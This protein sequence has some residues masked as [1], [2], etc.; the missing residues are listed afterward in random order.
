VLGS[1]ARR[2]LEKTLSRVDAVVAADVIG[3]SSRFYDSHAIML[4]NARKVIVGG[5]LAGSAD[6]G[7]ADFDLLVDGCLVDFKATRAAKITTQHL[8][9]LVGYW[10]LDYEDAL[11]IRS[12]RFSLL[13]HGHIEYFD[14]E[15]DLLPAGA[16]SVLR[17]TFRSELAR[18][19]KQSKDPNNPDH[20]KEMSSSR[21][22]T[23]RILEGTREA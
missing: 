9:Q 20:D 14:I 5:T 16:F 18:T 4:A 2:D 13:R 15:R 21:P 10:L 6:V 23:S 8:R 3:L 19:R 11:K 1:I 17:S 12:L 7:G 22:F